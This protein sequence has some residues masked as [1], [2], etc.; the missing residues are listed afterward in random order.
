MGQLVA[1]REPAV[2]T[3]VIRF[4]RAPA[5]FTLL[6]V[7]PGRG[8]KRRLHR[9]ERMR[10]AYRPRAAGRVD[11][12][13]TG[14]TFL[15]GLV[16]AGIAG[17]PVPVDPDQLVLVRHLRQA[18]LR[19]DRGAARGCDRQPG[20]QPADP[21]VVGVAVQQQVQVRSEDTVEIVGVA[22]VLVIGGGAADRVVVHG[23]D[24]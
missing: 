22:Q 8:R 20:G 6:V 19:V 21:A 14:P 3:P 13:I 23:T 10:C 17:E 1:V 24:P 12:Q 4:A 11:P 15:I 9:P 2:H 5:W 7:V 16:A 18:D